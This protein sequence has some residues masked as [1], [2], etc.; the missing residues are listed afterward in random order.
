MSMPGALSFRELVV[1]YAMPFWRAMLGL[2]QLSLLSNA[3]KVVKPAILAAVLATVIGGSSGP[4]STGSLFD[5]NHL[6]ARFL[7]WLRL[8]SADQVKTLLLLAVLYG[9]I[10]VVVAGLDYAASLAAFRIRILSARRIQLDL[11]RHMLSLS[12][13]YFHRQKSGELMSRVTQDATNT[14]YGLGPLIRSLVHQT[15]QLVAYSVYLFSSSVV[16]TIAALGFVAVHFGLTQLL[17]KP[18]RVW[19]RKMYDAMAGFSTTLQETLTSMRVAKSFSAEK[20][21]F[22]KLET[23]VEENSRTSWR[24]GRIERLEM[25]AR[26]VLDSLAAIGIFVIAIGQ[27]RAGALSVQ[28]LLLYIYVGQLII[29]PVSG[30]AHAFVS[31]QAL[32]AGF[33]RVNEILALRPQLRDGPTVKTAFQRRIEV[34][35]VWFSY[36]QGQALE[37]VSLEINKGEVVAFVGPSGAGKSTLADLILRLYDPDSGGIFIDDIDLRN[38]RQQEYRRL[39]GVVSQESLLFHDTVRNNIRYGRDDLTDEAIERAARIANAHDFIM[40]L[41]QGYDTAVGDRGVRLSGGQRQRVAIA[42]A[43]AANPPI[44][45]L[46]EATSSLDSQS[47]TLVQHAIDRVIETTTAIVIAHRLSTVLHADRIV[48]L[49]QRRLVDQ[50][51]HR[52]LLKRCRLYRELCSLQF[53]MEDAHSPMAVAER[54][55]AA[56]PMPTKG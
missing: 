37:D 6:G 10:G 42:R 14:A 53:A 33:E 16:L 24:Y 5:L 45:I 29:S 19:N 25:P 48:V 21:E 44:L 1:R 22:Q 15:V 49:D 55:P 28:G 9:A 3:L 17:K 7:Q 11:V 13:G 31:A 34:R 41:S 50:G 35:N 2:V 47:E 52:E 54:V 40:D 4:G 30:L 8:D 56:A 18:I 23:A 51:T 12:L 38:L 32:Q 26:A 36:G 27:L 39:F 20:F 43:V 46:D